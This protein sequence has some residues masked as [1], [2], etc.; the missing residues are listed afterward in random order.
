MAQRKVAEAF[1]PGEFILDELEARGWSQ[2]ELAEVIGC[3]PT[4]VNSWIKGKRALTAQTA[5]Q[6]ADAFGM[7]AQWWINIQS[8]YDLW[9]AGE[10]DAGIA[11]RARVYGYGPIKDLIRRQW[12]ESSESIEVLEERVLDFYCVPS[13]NE[14]PKLAHAARKSTQG[15]LTPSQSA[16][17]FRAKHLAK[18]INANRFTNESFVEVV[19]SLRSLMGNSED[20]RLVPKVLAQFGI[21]FVVVEP[22]VIGSGIDGVTLWDGEGHPIIAMSLRYDRIDSFWFTLGHELGHAKNGDGKDGNVILDV[23]LVGDKAQKR[24]DKPEIER[25][26]DLFSEEFLIPQMKLQSFIARKGPLFSKKKIT[27]FARIQGVHPGIVVGQLQFRE[28][29]HWSHYRSMLE[30]IRD[31]VKTSTL[32]DGWGQTPV[33]V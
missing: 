14:K 30:K 10:A 17:M 1:P 6:I 11:K 33:G 2:I 31:T 13:L 3:S 9:K 24:S 23:D 28:C 27:D 15:E 21:K 19:R 26:A 16:W 5:K 29:F 7:S 4:V 20:I 32:T 8:Y 25:L 22:L 12:I 18:C